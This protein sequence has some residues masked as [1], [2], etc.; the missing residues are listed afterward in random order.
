[1]VARSTSSPFYP[2]PP[3]V[4]IPTFGSV[5]VGMGKLR[6]APKGTTTGL[7]NSSN[8]ATKSTNQGQGAV[9]VL[10]RL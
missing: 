8:L 4:R 1:M 7:R 6:V 2:A 5:W 9:G 10:P 3:K